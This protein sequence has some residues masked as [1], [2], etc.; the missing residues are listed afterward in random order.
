M[1]SFFSRFKDNLK[2]DFGGRYLEAILM[3]VLKED[4]SILE[5][6]FP[7]IDKQIIKNR[8]YVEIGLEGIF[9]TQN[10]KKRFADL[11]VKYKGKY[12]ALLE[13]KY[14]DQ[15]LP[16][17]IA[18]Y[19]RYAKKNNICFTY[20]TQY[21][22]KKDDL[23]TIL[24]ETNDR[25][26]HLLYG[27][28]YKELLNRNK[29]RNPVTKL[30]CEFLEENVMIYDKDINYD[31]LLLLLI[32]GLYVKHN[33]GF[34][35]KV[36][37]ANVNSIPIIWDKLIGNVTVLGDRFYNDFDEYFNVRFSVDFGFIPEFNLKML[38]KD[39]AKSELAFDSLDRRRKIGGTFFITADGK[40]KQDKSDDWLSLSL[41]YQFH[42]DLEEKQVFN[43]LYTEVRG[44][45]SIFQD[46]SKKV[47]VLPNEDK[48]YSTLLKLTKDN[49]NKALK[50]HS[51]MQESFSNSLVEL[52][53]EINSKISKY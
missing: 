17:Q 18:D 38:S 19:I 26:K 22:P 10:K 31:S 15:P 3:E 16:N 50:E 21:P 35:R 48:C 29:N 28:F 7:K 34:G 39:I 44:K 51:N 41:G 32:K 20:L 27:K 13:I 9:P 8:K 25:Y 53:K 33:T 46:N 12:K 40:I 4:L 42:L 45:G 1:K 49:I 6:L 37:K 47:G 5:I 30:F 24:S 23:Q 43:Y 36:S 11:V 14:A 2:M 52:E